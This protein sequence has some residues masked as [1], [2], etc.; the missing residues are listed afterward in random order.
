MFKN[1]LN[2]IKT[3]IFQFIWIT[4]LITFLLFFLNIL[5]STSYNIWVFSDEIHNKLWMYFYIIDDNQIILDNYKSFLKNESSEYNSWNLQEYNSW[6]LQALRDKVQELTYEKNTDWFVF[7]K[8][9][10][11]KEILEKK[12]LNVKYYSKAD[13]FKLLDQRIPDV[14][15]SFKKYWID[16]PLPPTLYVTF[17]NEEEFNKMKNIVWKYEYLITNLNDIKEKTKFEEQEWRIINIINFTG[18]MMIFS[19]FLILML[20]VII[21]TFLLLIIKITFYNFYE[22]IEV[23]KLLWFNLFRIKL[24]FL[25]ETIIMFI[26]SFWLVILFLSIFLYYLNTHFIKLFDVNLMNLII[27]NSHTIYLWL[28]IEFVTL[29]TLWLIF[30]NFF[31]NKLIKK[32]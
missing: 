8:I 32:V 1:L 12:W 11:L 18:F 25:L 2:I 22:Q 19:Y 24:P 9:I 6:N 31:L 5:V 23:E 3:S 4:I 27:K 28:L 29:T 7:S 26:I 20:W 15:E 30:S 16:N 17:Q 10:E 14:I 21:F 13:V